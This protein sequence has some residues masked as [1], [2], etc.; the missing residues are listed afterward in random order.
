MFHLSSYKMENWVYVSFIQKVKFL[1][2]K[3]FSLILHRMLVIL[4]VIAQINILC[5]AQKSTFNRFKLYSNK[6]LFIKKYKLIKSTCVKLP[7]FKKK[8]SNKYITFID[9]GILH[10]DISK[11]AHIITKT[12]ANN[13]L[14]FLK[15]YLTK[16]S[17]AFHKEIIICLHPSSSYQLY[18]KELNGFKIYK[19][20]T[21]KYIL[22][23]SLLLFHDSTAIFSGIMLKKKI[24]SLKS[25]IMGPYLNAR[26]LFYKNTFSFEE[27]NIENS[28]TI[29]K[30][31]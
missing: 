11:R 16:L 1:F 29:K 20:K 7:L 4:K 22:D 26:R 13:Y 5:V 8:K 6:G 3:K 25:D 23:S 19:F 10:G 17:K 14:S 12:M 31:H 27:H 30:K 21:E 15:I 28:F 9:S 24:I 2:T 18:R